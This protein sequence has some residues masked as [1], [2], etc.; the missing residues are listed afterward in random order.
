[1]EVLNN[2]SLKEYNFTIWFFR[3]VLFIIISLVLLVV[4]FKINETVTISEGEIVAANPQVDYKA[5]SEVQIK[6]VYVREGQPVN[7]GDTLITLYNPEQVE[8]FTKTQ[9]E[10]EYLQNKSES[11]KVLENAVVSKKAAINQ[12]GT[13]AA[14]KYQ[15]EINRLVNSMKN[16]DQQYNLQKEKLSSNNEKFFGDSILYKKDMLSKYEFNNTKDASLAIK[17]NI[18]GTLSERRKAIDAKNMAYN[19]F[20]REQNSL[21][22][23]KIQLQE[24]QQSIEQARNQY[25]NQ[26]VQLQASLK[27]LGTQISQQTI[28]AQNAGIINFL[29]NTNKASNVIGKGELLVSLAPQANAFYAK[30]SVPEKDMPYLKSGLSAQLKLDAFNNFENGLLKGKVSYVSERKENEKFYALVTLPQVERFKLKPG[31]T[32]YGKIII[33]R[34]PLYKFFIKRLFKK[35]DT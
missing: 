10:I 20:T 5:P 7:I 12:S 19:D 2:Y 33:E 17:E 6:K 9:A 13:I 24:N 26:L 32:V 21:M 15:I 27:R 29:F 11:L 8:E 1:M 34:L 4:F 3:I 14:N 18:T 28:I 30:V 22:L 35:F 23:N 25:E 16:L 31:Y